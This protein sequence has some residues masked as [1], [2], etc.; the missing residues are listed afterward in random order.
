[1][2]GEEYS[3]PPEEAEQGEVVSKYYTREETMKLLEV[4]EEELKRLIQQRE[5]R[6]AYVGKR[7]MFP[8]KDV[9]KLVERRASEP[10]I[11]LSD[12]DAELPI[13]EEL[14]GKTEEL[15]EPSEQ[16]RF[17][18]RVRLW[19][20]KYADRFNKAKTREERYGVVQR[21]LQEMHNNSYIYG[22]P[23]K[24]SEEEARKLFDTLFKKKGGLHG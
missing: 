21:Y 14:Y 18:A 15:P 20:E 12:S 22:D 9:D 17:S 19:E 13:P 2:S 8:K 4:D 3:Q 5:V 1:M 16:E 6:A 23:S 24:D 10:T 11:I 7:V